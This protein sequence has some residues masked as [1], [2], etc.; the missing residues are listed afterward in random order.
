[1]LSW[2]VFPISVLFLIGAGVTHNL[3]FYRI[4]LVA[5][6]VSFASILMDV[7]VFRKIVFCVFI[8]VMRICLITTKAIIFA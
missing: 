5:L 7:T 4:S 8:A 6:L 1:M 2:S 3:F